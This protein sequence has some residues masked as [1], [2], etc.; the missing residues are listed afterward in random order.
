M[1]VA[2]GA[3]PMLWLDIRQ[4]WSQHRLVFTH[5]HKLFLAEGTKHVIPSPSCGSGRDGELEAGVGREA[6]KEAV[7]HQG[8]FD[9]AVP[10]AREP[11]WSKCQYI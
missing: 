2:M 9:A 6:W 3:L 10:L 11:H 1:D 4:L 5:L 8:W 7:Y